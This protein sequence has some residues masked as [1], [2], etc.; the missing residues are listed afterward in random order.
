MTDA[1]FET[2]AEG[3]RGLRV[4][5]LYAC[6]AVSDAALAHIAGLQELQ[7]SYIQS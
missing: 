5:R 6:S 1:G 7:V 2:A 4:L 3:C